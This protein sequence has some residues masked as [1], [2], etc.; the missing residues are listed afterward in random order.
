MSGL[1]VVVAF[2]LAALALY[3]FVGKANES[4][5]FISA[6]S[7]GYTKTVQTLQGR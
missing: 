5:I 4:S 6:L 1:Q 3:F 7:D 2:T